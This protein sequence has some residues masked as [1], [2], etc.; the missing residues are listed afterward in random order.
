MYAG[1]VHVSS[2]VINTNY[3]KPDTKVNNIYY[4]SIFYVCKKH[5]FPS[6]NKYDLLLLF[7]ALNINWRFLNAKHL[8]F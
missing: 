8:W 2:K 5:H 3:S 1:L 4:S 6:F 7:K